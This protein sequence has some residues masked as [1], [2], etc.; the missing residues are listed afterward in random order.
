[1]ILEFIVGVYVVLFLFL[2]FLKFK[3]KSASAKKV[4]FFHPFW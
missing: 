4:A 1:M 3:T 2:N